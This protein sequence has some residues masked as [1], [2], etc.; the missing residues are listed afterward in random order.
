MY[1]KRHHSCRKKMKE[2]MRMVYLHLYTY[3]NPPEISL[4]KIL[5][6]QFFSTALYE[7]LNYL[8]I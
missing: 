8:P 1:E 7:S 6:L 2:V 5:L 3:I 4:Q